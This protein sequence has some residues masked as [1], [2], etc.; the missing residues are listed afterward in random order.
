MLSIYSFI[1][2][3]N[4]YRDTNIFK[5]GVTK[6]FKKNMDT[7]LDGQGFRNKVPEIG[8]CKQQKFIFS[9]LDAGRPRS[10]GL[11][12]SILMRHLS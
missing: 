6:N 11:Q 3:I 10:R 5:T 8:C 1:I 12:G 7:I 9:V 4:Y 2:D